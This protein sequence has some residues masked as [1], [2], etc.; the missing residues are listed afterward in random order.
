MSIAI[1]EIT[2][3][4][5]QA[6]TMRQKEELSKFNAIGWQVVLISSQGKYEK[7]KLVCNMHLILMN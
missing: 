3:S 7:E 6:E 1:K 2:I 5:A 4:L